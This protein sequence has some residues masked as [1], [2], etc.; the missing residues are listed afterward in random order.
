MKPFLVPF[1]WALALCAQPAPKPA[2]FAL[3]RVLAMPIAVA[4]TQVT[5]DQIGEVT[6]IAPDFFVF[7]AHTTVAK[8]GAF[9]MGWGTFS[10]KAGELKTLLLDIKTFKP[11]YGTF[12][13]KSSFNPDRSRF[14]AREGLLYFTVDSGWVAT[15]PDMHQGWT[16]G[17]Y[18]WDGQ[19]VR[20]ILAQGDAIVLNG[21]TRTVKSA[22]LL[23]VQP[24][25][26]CLAYLRTDR[27]NGIVLWR[28]DIVEPWLLEK[29]P[30]PGGTTLKAFERLLG[31]A[32]QGDGLFAVLGPAQGEPFLAAIAAGKVTKV[33]D[34]KGPDP[35]EPASRIYHV[36][37]ADAADANAAAIWAYVYQGGKVDRRL[38]RLYLWDQGSL[39]RVYGTPDQSW[40]AGPGD[41]RE[42]A[43]GECWW[44]DRATRRFLVLNQ[45]R[46]DGVTLGLSCRYFDGN[47]LQDVTV[48]GHIPNILP[49]AWPVPAGLA[50][51]GFHCASPP[52]G[53]WQPVSSLFEPKAP[54]RL[55]PGGEYVSTNQVRFPLT[56][57]RGGDAT[58]NRYVLLL[59]DGFHLT[60]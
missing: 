57:I 28:N 39:R 20:K 40:P 27:E 37:R 22:N 29:G 12:P 42:D 51:T 16:G 8:P 50:V 58:A 45:R 35:L 10:W 3:E 55:Q 7:T 9:N 17:L 53:P 24:G 44:T 1:C 5:L 19:Q 38:G 41:A 56:A 43:F 52:R 13:E 15:T 59:P 6:V 33:L 34:A 18:S 30:I 46:L 36:A 2:P 60:K 48:A 14:I 11:L 23:A 21:G 31:V 25:G 49:R 47:A 4:D 32:P 54:Y 26:G